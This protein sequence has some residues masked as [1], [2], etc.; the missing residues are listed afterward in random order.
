MSVNLA[1][2]QSFEGIRPTFR[3]LWKY[4]LTIETFITISKIFTC[5][6]SLKLIRDKSVKNND[7]K[8]ADHS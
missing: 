4:F 7:N 2:A 1:K 5:I 3:V 8:K 6:Y